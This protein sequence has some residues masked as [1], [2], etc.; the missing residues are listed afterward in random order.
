MGHDEC[1]GSLL[2]VAALSQ[3]EASYLHILGFFRVLKKAAT[4]ASWT[5]TN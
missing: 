5:R 4:I 1:I 2:K 3:Q